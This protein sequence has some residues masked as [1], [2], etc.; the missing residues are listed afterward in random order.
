MLFSAFTDLCERLEVI[1]GRLEMVGV[2]AGVLEGLPDE[3]L[4]VF[5][6]F[7]M[8]RVKASPEMAMAPTP[9]PM[10]TRSMML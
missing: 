10:N 1:S 7:I 2:L 9:W 5:T 8:G 3:E 4:P 6:R